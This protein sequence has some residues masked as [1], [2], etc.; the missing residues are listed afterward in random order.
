MRTEKELMR[1]EDMVEQFQNE[2]ESIVAEDKVSILI[3]Y[4][5]KKHGSYKGYM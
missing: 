1:H 3:K 5:T 2:Y 4:K